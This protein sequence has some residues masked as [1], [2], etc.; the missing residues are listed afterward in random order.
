MNTKQTTSINT[1]RISLGKQTRPLCTNH[2]LT[3]ARQTATN[4]RQATTHNKKQQH[5]SIANNRQRR[6]TPNNNQ[7]YATTKQQ[8]QSSTK[9]TT[10]ALKQH[11]TADNDNQTN[12]K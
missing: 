8:Q 7:Q 3:H 10:T 4:T 1:Q 2:Y 5:Q 12:N 9:I 6:Q 11:A